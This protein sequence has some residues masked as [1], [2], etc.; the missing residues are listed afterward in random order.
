MKLILK[1]F[2]TI[3]LLN[4]CGK[5]GSENPP[6]KELGAFNLIFPDNNQLC[7]EGQ[8]SGVDNTSIELKWTASENATSYIIELVNQSNNSI[9][10]L[11]ASTSSKTIIV[12]KNTQFTWKVLAQ[13]DETTKESS[14]W[15]FYTEGN[16]VDNYTPFPA[17]ITFKDNNDNTIDVFWSST[18]LDNDSITYDIYIGTNATPPIFLE[19]T[20]DTSTTNYSINYGTTYTIIVI[21]KDSNNNSATNKTYFKF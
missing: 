2:L 12:T 18:D 10:K 21:S 9:E 4:S 6:K 1:L 11:T 13:L 7:T 16:S 17:T 14:T 3:L 5:S 19:N 20:T 15:N 8:D